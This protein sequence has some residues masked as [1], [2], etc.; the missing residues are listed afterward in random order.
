MGNSRILD[1]GINWVSKSAKKLINDSTAIEKTQKNTTK[2]VE[3]SVKGLKKQEKTL[4]DNLKVYDKYINSLRSLNRAIKAGLDTN[5]ITRPLT[6][7]NKVIGSVLND[8]QDGVRGIRGTLQGVSI[9]TFK[10]TF[11][12]IPQRFQA[13]QKDI[14]GFRESLIKTFPQLEG[15]FDKVEQKLIK[16][17]LIAQSQ[18][19]QA[20][21][22][23]FDFVSGVRERF[24]NFDFS[25]LNFSSLTA[26]LSSIGSVISGILPA[27]SGFVTTLTATL[28]PILAPLAA[29]LVAVG[30]AFVGIR[31]ALRSVAIEPVTRSFNNL[32]ANIPNGNRLLGGLQEAAGNTIAKFDLLKIANTALAGATGQ[33]KQTLGR[34]LPELLTIARVQAQ[35]T[36]QS[37][38]FLFNSLVS[39]I[40]RG[41]PLLI[42][43]TGLV[44]KVGEANEQYA[45]SIG[46]TVDQLTAQ[47]KQI[48]L[49]QATLT[50]GNKAIE[51]AGGVF[52][53]NIERVG[54]VRAIFKD[55][56]ND[57][58]VAFQP[59]L[60]VLLR[61]ILPA[62]RNLQTNMGHVNRVIRVTSEIVRELFNILVLLLAPFRGL[63]S[64]MQ[65]V[66]NIAF[67]AFVF[68][69]RSVVETLKFVGQVINAV[70]TPFR[71]LPDT[72][73]FV[74]FRI[75][76]IIEVFGFLA[77]Q[78]FGRV[79]PS[80]NIFNQLQRVFQNAQFAINNF[81]T[82]SILGFAAWT[83]ALINSVAQMAVT[84]LRIIAD[85]TNA[86][87]DFLIGQSPPPKGAL[88]KI[89]VGGAN[90]F[91]AWLDGFTSVSLDPVA[92]VVSEV[93]GYL[94]N[95]ANL[96]RSQVES[97]LAQLDVALQPF[98][99]RVNILNAQLQQLK[100]PLDA[101]ISGLES[102]QEKLIKQ[103]NAGNFELAE[104]IKLIDAQKDQI[105]NLYDAEQARAAQAQYQLTLK[106]AEQAEE[107]ALLNL[108]LN[109][110]GA[111]QKISNAVSAT[112]NAS[113]VGS[114][115]PTPS[116][117]TTE[118]NA[119]G[120][121][122]E[123]TS[124]EAQIQGFSPFQQEF[125]SNLV[126]P[127]LESGVFGD[128]AAQ[129]A[130][131]GQGGSKISKGINTLP[132]RIA[133]SFS[134]IG[135]RI[136]GYFEG[137]PDRIRKILDF[138]FGTTAKRIFVLPVARAINEIKIKFDEITDKIT[139]VFNNIP[140]F[141][142][143]PL[144]DWLVN[145]GETDE[146]EAPIVTRLNNIQSEFDSFSF[147]EIELP[148]FDS[149]GASF[150]LFASGAIESLKPLT[151]YFGAVSLEGS[152]LYAITQFNN[153][154][155]TLRE[156]GLLPS[157]Q[158]LKDKL[159]GDE[160]ILQSILYWFSRDNEAGLYATISLAF[161]NIQDN[162]LFEFINKWI[163]FYN[164]LIT[165][166]SGFGTALGT[167]VAN[168]VISTF[169]IIIETINGVVQSI[170]DT[171][172]S[173][174]DDAIALGE[175]APR[176]VGI[177]SAVGQL[178]GF[179]LSVGRIN[180]IPLVGAAKGGLF[181]EGALQVGERG[182]E[183][184]SS[185]T[186]Q[187]V[188]PNSFVTSMDR[189][190]NVMTELVELPIMQ[191]GNNFNNSSMT[192]NSTMIVNAQTM[193]GV[194]LEQVRN[195]ARTR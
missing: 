97:R 32:V 11:D 17:R 111:E 175:R 25:K 132:N 162:V 84:I 115:K 146:S 82:N 23:F 36:G 52:V 15:V 45:E 79:A 94:G 91:K 6:N 41:S 143:I 88:S 159:I 28:L 80:F 124:S 113:G 105:N 125:L 86:I 85:L 69:L 34:E 116:N 70:I 14:A 98:Q 195:L 83:G 186:K 160:G 192:N 179:R 7:I 29:G 144:P 64:L 178:E 155:F 72:I 157:F 127:S 163:I 194:T 176:G 173:L 130:R 103:F 8:F 22:K 71:I 89:D 78:I 92:N 24:S 63:G 133:D 16:F 138:D 58:G 120:E 30:V 27:V 50:A 134:T 168:P 117:G 131:I 49:L 93:N 177:R 142:N 114:T 61:F 100:A 139:S 19:N 26:G 121:T 40:K 55:I 44:L 76:E 62:L 183:I 65:G 48:A 153:G 10:E 170:Q 110:L 161:Q 135:D 75:R 12:L 158:I 119:L 167:A 21:T 164:D 154:L 190:T 151:D 187:A 166:F 147:P 185:A 189:L 102:Q 108:Q 73:G 66:I 99:N 101:A 81:I 56:R 9:G 18:L 67:H 180:T 13:L 51:Q 128:I 42:D 106:Q 112:I 193:D 33:V 165:T 54:E 38:E 2:L 109:R 188:F 90:T 150:S 123:L 141:P 145:N 152:L 87:G 77:N 118:S 107:R 39:G 59:L 169:N 95:I 122:P 137:I 171:I 136:V 31:E 172:N 37:V 174:I 3:E 1:L 53:T 104:Q 149:V 4:E 191:T 60:E 46:K 184:V 182:R 126:N 148:N 47:E 57:F 20:K 5:P 68:T 140:P 129:Q 74:I 35:A 181:S 156:N 43:N 96:T